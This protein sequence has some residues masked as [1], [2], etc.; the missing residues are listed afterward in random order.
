LTARRSTSPPVDPAPPAPDDRPVE[1]VAIQPHGALLVVDPSTFRLLRHSGTAPALLHI[2]DSAAGERLTEIDTDGWADLVDQLVGRATQD[3]GAE[4]VVEIGDARFDLTATAAGDVVLVEFEPAP[5]VVT[6]VFPA[7]RRALDRVAAVQTPTELFDVAVAVIAELAGFDRTMAY[8]VE[9]DGSSSIVAERRPAT[10]QPFLGLHFVTADPSSKEFSHRRTCRHT[11]DTEAAGTPVRPGLPPVDLGQC[12]L[13]TE[14]VRRRQFVAEMG[15][16]ASLTLSVIVDGRL[17]ALIDCVSATPRL[18]PRAV[19]RACDIVAAQVAVGWAG[20]VQAQALADDLASKELRGQL[21]ETLSSAKDLAAE[22]VSGEHTLTDLIPADAVVARIG[23]DRAASRGGPSAAAIR[24]LAQHAARL[25]AGD[26][27][28]TTRLHADAPDLARALPQYAGVLLVSLGSGDLLAWLR[29][30]VERTLTWF[31]EQTPGGRPDGPAAFA[32]RVETSTDQS[33]PWTKAHTATAFVADLATVQQR[34]TEAAYAQ[35]SWYDE[36]TE[37][38][39]RRM[40]VRVLDHLLGEPAHAATAVLFID[41]DRFKTVNDEHGHHVGDALLIEVA[42]R[43]SD[44]IRHHDTVA[45]LGGD[46]FV[47]ICPGADRA[48]ADH[49]AERVVA[50]FRRPIRI[51]GLSLRVTASVGIVDAQPHA[52]SADVLQAAD[53]AMYQAKR[54]GRNRY[55]NAIVPQQRRRT[56]REDD[57]HQAS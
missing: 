38:P 54:H 42:R 25:P 48:G 50:A 8:L 39:N 18:V 30:P 10:E 27:W 2:P 14:S 11:V 24:E 5:E 17:I 6:S 36:L 19:R 55:T 31:D 44:V 51:A 7:L 29:R 45:R 15:G 34:R 56:D 28:H 53:A 12:E 40:A 23:S 1:P 52:N 13:A 47:M 3:E 37:L 41:L 49:I 46:E 20:M 26:I 4:A 21:V 43:L 33:P 35:L 16:R 22:M 9:P 32:L 57:T